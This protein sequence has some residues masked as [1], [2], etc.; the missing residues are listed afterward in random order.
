MAKLVVISKSGPALVHP[1]GTQWVTIGRSPVNNLQISDSS[2]SGSHC[3]VR[4]HNNELEVRDMRSTNGTFIRGQMIATGVVRMGEI[5]RVGEIELR[6]EPSSAQSVWPSRN[7]LPGMPVPK[8]AASTEP[9]GSETKVHDRSTGTKRQVLLVDDSM[10]L[11][12]TAAELF[13]TL[14]NGAWHVHQACG[15]DEALSI[16]QQHR[17]EVAAIDVSMPM[18][19]GLQ[20]LAML[21]RR[22]PDVK[23]VMLTG[24][25]SETYRAQCLAAGAELFLEKPTTRDGFKFVFNVLNDL[26]TWKPAD[27]FSGTLQHVGLNDVI[28]IECLRRNSCVLQIQ[29]GEAR[30]EIYIES[31]VIIHAAAGQDHGENALHKLLGLTHGRFELSPFQKPSDRTISGAWEWLLMESARVRDEEKG[32]AAEEKTTFIERPDVSNAAEDCIKQPVTEERCAAEPE[33]VELPD[34]GNEIVVVSTYDGE[35]KSV[36]SE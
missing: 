26:I 30:G 11:L 24:V 36:P 12:E 17:I 13:E 7:G 31:G 16:M 32:K 6:L 15:A 3:E 20:L 33:Q 18:L 28:Q 4:F 8:A 35:W 29:N 25:P 22:H 1:L 19:D 10:A 34:L 23:K 9:N 5:L 21:H 27:G 2:V 14:S